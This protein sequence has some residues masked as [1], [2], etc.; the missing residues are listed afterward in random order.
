MSSFPSPPLRTPKPSPPH[1]CY[2]EGADQAQHPSI[3][4][5]AWTPRGPYYWELRDHPLT[6]SSSTRQTLPPTTLPH[7]WKANHYHL[8]FARRARAAFV[9]YLKPLVH[10]LPHPFSLGLPP[11]SSL[12]APFSPMCGSRTPGCQVQRHSGT[13]KK[14][15]GE[16][17]LI[18]PRLPLLPFF[19]APKPQLTG[20]GRSA[21]PA[22]ARPPGSSSSA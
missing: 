6:S 20:T 9:F 4:T 2:K 21:V 10:L 16:P 3:H 12:P 14:Q 18:W 15:H 7:F 1:S 13:A 11:P 17:C 19:P 5:W 22:P 8:C